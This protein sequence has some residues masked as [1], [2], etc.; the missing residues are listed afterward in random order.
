V[1][2]IVEQHHGWIKVESE[3][4]GGT[5][6]HIYLPALVETTNMRIRQPAVPAVRKGTET[7]L[8]V[9]DETPVR[10]LMQRILKSHGY[11]VHEAASG[12]SALKV[13]EEHRAAIDLLLT[14]MVMPEGINGRELAER[15]RSEK[16][17][18]KV[19]YCSGYTDELLGTDSLLRYNVNFLE[20]PFEVHK[21]LQRIRDCL[22]GR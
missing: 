11:Q 4:G 9:E 20:K 19:I 18:L 2:G 6:F 5:A 17:A 21:F 7:I 15:M 22:D 14:D 10:Q 12:L 3:V 16:P 13:W 1:F 8:L